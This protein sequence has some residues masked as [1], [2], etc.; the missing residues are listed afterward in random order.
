MPTFAG[1]EI[2]PPSSGFF[3]GAAIGVD[4]GDS[5]GEA[6]PVGDPAR[7]S[8]GEGVAPGDAFGE[9]PVVGDALGDG[10][11][12]LPAGEGD[13]AGG[14]GDWAGEGAAAGFTLTSPC[15]GGSWYLQTY[16]YVPGVGNLRG[17]EDV[18]GGTSIS[19][20]LPVAL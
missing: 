14:E 9:A 8:A 12:E 16:E 11:G 18:P 13:W 1:V 5:V 7:V 3:G 15:I 20:L 6:S 2:P 4:V 17:A 19:K 10:L